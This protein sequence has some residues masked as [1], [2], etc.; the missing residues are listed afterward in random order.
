MYIAK[1]INRYITNSRTSGRFHFNLFQLT[2]PSL[3]SVQIRIIGV[4]LD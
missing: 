4:T 3:I 2:A 1:L